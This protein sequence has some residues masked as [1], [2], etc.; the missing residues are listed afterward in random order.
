MPKSKGNKSRRKARD[1]ARLARK[2]PDAI[3]NAGIM[4]DLT[5]ITLSPEGA[6]DGDCPNG[7]SEQ[8]M[9]LMM[10]GIAPRPCPHCGKT[11]QFDDVAQNI[12]ADLPGYEPDC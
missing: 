9:D 5:G 11:P 6:S 1:T 12:S 10:F 4:P 3:R 8:A 2:A 7:H